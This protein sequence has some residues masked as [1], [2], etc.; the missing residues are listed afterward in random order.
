MRNTEYKILNPGLWE[1]YGVCSTR[2]RWTSTRRGRGR[3]SR[4]RSTTSNVD[5]WFGLVERLHAQDG[6]GIMGL[7]EQTILNSGSGRRS[8]RAHGAK[9][10]SGKVGLENAGLVGGFC[11]K[12]GPPG[13]PEAQSCRRIRKQ[14]MVSRGAYDASDETGRA[15]L[16]SHGTRCHTRWHTPA[17]AAV[18]AV[19]S[20]ERL[21]PAETSK[22]AR[23][24]VPDTA[25]QIGGCC[26]SRLHTPSLA[27]NSRSPP[28]ARVTEQPGARA[29]NRRGRRGWEPSLPR[30]AARAVGQ[31]G[32][33][34][35][36]TSTSRIL[37]K[38]FF[39]RPACPQSGN[40]SGVL[41]RQQIA[42]DVRS[43]D[44]ISFQFLSGVESDLY[45]V[46]WTVSPAGCCVSALLLAS[47][48]LTAVISFAARPLKQPS[49]A[50]T[51]A[52]GFTRVALD[53]FIIR[54]GFNDSI[55]T[56]GGPSMS[57]LGI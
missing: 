37:W 14:S 3:R 42:S 4:R 55:Q 46:F 44:A 18:P 8:A 34:I 9:T 52:L 17:R 57:D 27:P 54:R 21:G 31:C 51:F 29:G 16:P 41:Q 48:S 47:P 23:S 20:G 24:A 32:L 25:F 12:P 50:R 10:E 5:V 39:A 26:L 7:A 2:R 43:I 35:V 6:T 22:R 38:C 19:P 56:T 28:H 45:S 13:L 33:W 36:E 53:V 15:R 49:I 11:T 40:P 1:Y 30:L